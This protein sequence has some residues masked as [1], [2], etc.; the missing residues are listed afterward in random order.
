MF[1]INLTKLTKNIPIYKSIDSRNEMRD[2]LNDNVGE[3]HISK[4]GSILVNEGNGWKVRA[5][6]TSSPLTWYVDFDDEL[7]ALMFRL[8]FS[9]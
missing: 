8:R 3:Y 6:A 2:W 7:Y 4:T 9:S 5:D 1:S